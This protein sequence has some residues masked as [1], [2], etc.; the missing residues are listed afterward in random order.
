MARKKEEMVYFSPD[1]NLMGLGRRISVDKR[2]DKFK[3]PKKRVAVAV[4]RKF[5]E[6]YGPLDQR[7]TPQCVGYAGWGWLAAGPVI[8]KPRYKPSQLYRMAQDQ[9]EWP[10]SNYEG[11]SVLGLMKALKN[12]GY[13]DEYV[14][15]KKQD[16]IVAWLLSTGPVILGTTWT[17]D[18]F[19]PDKKG[20]ISFTGE[21]VGGHAYRL[22]GADRDFECPDGSK[23]AVRLVNSWGW[24]W[25][26]NGRAW[27]SLKTLQDLLDDQGEAVTAPE[28]KL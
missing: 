2:S 20:F 8:N 14:W 15:A 6:D 11:T 18:M 27:L 9:D 28:I 13:V 5:W 4:R 22:I 26:Q 24:K 7:N 23:G 10:G 19:M 21:A 3:M 25:G 17:V 12:I 16:V 1:E